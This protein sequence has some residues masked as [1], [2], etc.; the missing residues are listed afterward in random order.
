MTSSTGRQNKKVVDIMIGLIIALLFL[1]GNILTITEYGLGYDAGGHMSRGEIVLHFYGTGEIDYNNLPENERCR[2]QEN[3]PTEYPYFTPTNLF[4]GAG[5]TTMGGIT[6][7]VTCAIFHKHFKWLDPVDAHNLGS[8]LFG[9]LTI[10]VVYLFALEAFGRKEA[11]LSSIFLAL[12]PPFIGHSHISIKDMS[13]VFF[14]SSTVWTFW[15]GVVNKSYKWICISSVLL[16]MA[17]ISKMNGA[18]AVLIIGAWVLY[19]LKKQTFAIVPK[20]SLKFWTVLLAAPIIVILVYMLFAPRIW[21]KTPYNLIENMGKT[22]NTMLGMKEY[23]VTKNSS[24]TT[25]H[26]AANKNLWRP[27]YPIIHALFAIPLPVLFFSLFGVWF[28]VKESQGD[29]KKHAVLVL[30]W[31]FVPVLFCMLPYILTYGAIRQ[32]LPYVPGVCLLA[33]IGAVSFCSVFKRVATKYLPPEKISVCYLGFLTLMIIS[34]AI[35]VLQYHPYEIVFKNNLIG[36]LKGAQEIQI[37][38][39]HRKGIPDYG[40]VRG[41]SIRKAVKWLDKHGEPGSALIVYGTPANKFLPLKKSIKV[42]PYSW[43]EQLATVREMPFKTVYF[44][45]SNTYWNLEHTYYGYCY[46]NLSPLYTGTANGVEICWV[47]QMSRK[48]FL[49]MTS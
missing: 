7:A 42:F 6:S 37:P 21:F 8:L 19:L 18:Y 20:K 35:S 22:V 47:Y 30:A 33:G 38:F 49:E 31:A 32:I 10:L 39:A 13:V 23:V 27:Y 48:D 36:G 34:E 24:I 29:Y 14:V 28:V 1:L 46:N 11:V 44:I 43:Q 15:K 40:D 16:G 2:F 4:M 45:F 12:F 5:G 41:T 17:L 26:P 3:D 9:A 25:G